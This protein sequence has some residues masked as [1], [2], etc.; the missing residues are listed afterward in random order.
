[1]EEKQKLPYPTID[2]CK[3]AR[4][5]KLIAPFYAGKRG[6]LASVSQCLYQSIR[7]SAK[8]KEVGA[9]ILERIAES[10]AL[11]FQLLGK[12]LLALGV[13]PVLSVA[14]PQKK[15]WFD[16]SAVSTV[17]E[18]CA[19]VLETLMFKRQTAQSYTAAASKVQNEEVQHLLLRI[20]LDEKNHAT[21]LSELYKTLCK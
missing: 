20:A 13:D 10:D 18:P 16:T 11:H 5:A 21:A 15:K 8:Q 12:A 2:A 7:L 9:E 4:S 1:M 19:M 6:E 17:Q 3:D 14:P